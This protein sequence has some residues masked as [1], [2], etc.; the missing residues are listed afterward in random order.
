V[1]ALQGRPDAVYDPASHRAIQ[2][3]ILGTNGTWAAFFY[4]P[5]WL[6]V[7]LP[8]ALLPFAASA[9][10]FMAVTGALFVT[11]FK[12][13]LPRAPFGVIAALTYASVWIN[14][15]GVQNG[16]LISALFMFGIRWLD[17]VPLLAGLCLGCII[18]KPQF[19]IVLP[20]VL[21]AS[22]RWTVMLSTAISALSLVCMSAAVFGIDTWIAFVRE[23]PVIQ[24]DVRFNAEGPGKILSAMGA[25]RLLGA[26]PG[27]A[28]AVQAMVTAACCV[29][30]WRFAGRC[31][32]HAALGAMICVSA[33]LA[34]PWLHTYD[35]AILAFP[36]AWL[37][38]DRSREKFRW[39][40]KITIFANYAVPPLWPL[41][42]ALQRIPVT[43]LIVSALLVV[44]WRRAALAPSV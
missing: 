4:P 15:I 7:C 42:T 6:L 44:V 1:L 24:N 20:L 37:L 19:G 23:L 26:A 36:L 39:W 25:A 33:V 10:T 38:T 30:V 11:A 5:T 29:A 2:D 34:S 28:Y 9:L 41:V 12:A 31:R 35:L 22:R 27:F 14:L 18:V 21:A 13:S 40:E 32:E 17:R 3:T 8:L 16:L 43:P